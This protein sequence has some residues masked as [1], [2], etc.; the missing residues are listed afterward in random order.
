MRSLSCLTKISE[1]KDYIAQ[2]LKDQ[3]KAYFG[4]GVVKDIIIRKIVVR[5]V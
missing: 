2:R 3:S 4:E 1:A 5:V